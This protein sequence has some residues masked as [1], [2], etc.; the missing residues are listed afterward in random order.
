MDTSIEP[1]ILSEIPIEKFDD[2]DGNTEETEMKING[3]E[4][5]ILVKGNVVVSYR[6]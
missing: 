6:H 4:I 1:E 3:D 2:Y 5:E